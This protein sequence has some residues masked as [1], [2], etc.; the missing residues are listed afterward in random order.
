MSKFRLELKFAVL[1][2]ALVAIFQVANAEPSCGPMGTLQIS[3]GKDVHGNLQNQIN[4]TVRDS[5][6]K[7]IKSHEKWF[8]GGNGTP[9]KM[10]P[11]LL[12]KSGAFSGLTVITLCEPTG[13]YD[14]INL[15]TYQISL[16]SG[17]MDLLF[18]DSING[19][20]WDDYGTKIFQ[21]CL[22][23]ASAMNRN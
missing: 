19:G 2:L 8:Q 18:Q 21:E 3:I 22:D 15:T 1:F 12:S 14:S 20:L 6:G 23:R 4:F 17:G 10:L 16:P 5:N 7:L 11:S 9:G 13:H